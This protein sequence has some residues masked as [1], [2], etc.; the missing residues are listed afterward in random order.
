MLDELAAVELQ[1][2][3]HITTNKKIRG[4]LQSI[5][6]EKELSHIPNSYNLEKMFSARG[7]NQP[8]KVIICSA[9]KNAGYKIVMSYLHP[10]TIK[11][12]APFEFLRKVYDEWWLL[13]NDP[14][15]KG[16]VNFNIDVEV[17]KMIKEYPPRF[18]PNPEKNWG[19]KSAAKIQLEK[20]N[21]QKEV[22]IEEGKKKVK[23]D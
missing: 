13:D 15:F 10:I 20:K 1:G 8:K 9:I 16:E 6:N 23:S 18:L 4:F 7:K 2:P 12:D 21:G 22:N 14:Q 19:P 11:T 17:K 5:I 3:L